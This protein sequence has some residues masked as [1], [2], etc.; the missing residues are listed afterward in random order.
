MAV[1]GILSL[2]ETFG[3]I[4]PSENL[5]GFSVHSP[6]LPNSLSCVSELQGSEEVLG[7]KP[8]RNEENEIK[9]SN[10][11]RNAREQALFHLLTV[12]A[13]DFPSTLA[14]VMPS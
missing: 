8:S 4:I 2:L 14:S 9:T 10:V 13:S 6:V 11:S 5:A 1:D 12:R 3:S 7:D